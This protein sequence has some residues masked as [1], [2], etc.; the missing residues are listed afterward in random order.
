MDGF[1]H[2]DRFVVAACLGIAVVLV[3]SLHVLDPSLDPALR[4]MSEY[5]RGP[6]GALMR[7]VF[8]LLAA[9]GAVVTTTLRRSGMPRRALGLGLW[10]IGMLVA[11]LFVTDSSLPDAPHT[12][13]GLVHDAAAD[14]AFLALVLGAASKADV[15]RVAA[16]AMVVAVVLG[17]LTG[18]AG[19]GQRCFAGIAIAW[20]LWLAFGAQRAA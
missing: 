3:V 18:C 12:T 1:T 8:V 19:L 10:S 7:A 6:W 4:F 16:A 11:G 2:R 9:G 15:G 14:F 13:T 17:R 20:Q 5:A